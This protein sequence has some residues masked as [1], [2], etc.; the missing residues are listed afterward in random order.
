MKDALSIS[1]EG[2]DLIRRWDTA[3]KRVEAAK[4][5]LNSAE[6]ELANSTNALGKWMVPAPKSGE[7]PPIGEQF[8]ICIENGFLAVKQVSANDFEVKWRVKPRSEHSF[9]S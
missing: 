4:R 3:Q 1:S 2:L 6:A 8:N 5:E 9:L 7:Q